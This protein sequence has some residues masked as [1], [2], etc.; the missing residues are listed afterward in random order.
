MRDL[1]TDWSLARSTQPFFCHVINWPFNKISKLNLTNLHRTQGARCPS[2]RR[3]R[4]SSS[5]PWPPSTTRSRASPRR[6]RPRSRPGSAGSGRWR[7]GPCRNRRRW[8]R[9][10]SPPRRPR[11]RC[12]NRV[13]HRFTRAFHGWMELGRFMFSSPPLLCRAM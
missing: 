1:K 5:L 10:T 6:G 2:R 3:P 4:S 12:T 7:C 11:V 9:R 8:T 13:M